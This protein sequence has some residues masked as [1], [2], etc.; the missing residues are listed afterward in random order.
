MIEAFPDKASKWKLLYYKQGVYLYG[1]R[2]LNMKLR[3]KLLKPVVE[4]ARKLGITYATCR[5]GL[6]SKDFFNALSCDGTH[7]IPLM[8]NFSRGR[9]YESTR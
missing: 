9:G 5:E 7:L 6:L 2:Y 1:Y 4:A 8:E 3:K